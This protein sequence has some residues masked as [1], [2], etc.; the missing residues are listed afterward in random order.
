LPKQ[1]RLIGYL[2]SKPLIC[3]KR[4]LA[5]TEAALSSIIC[6][7]NGSSMDSENSSLE[8]DSSFE[9]SS[10]HENI[11]NLTPMVPKVP[12]SSMMPIKIPTKEV[13]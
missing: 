11:L 9:D 10:S 3:D 6:I 2:G 1:L 8:T 4:P 12:K 5:L 13:F 7:L